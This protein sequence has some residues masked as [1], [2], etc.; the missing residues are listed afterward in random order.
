MREASG[1]F[2]AIGW[3]LAAAV[4]LAGCAQSVE[5]PRGAGDE[6]SSLAAENDEAAATAG[7]EIGTVGAGLEASGKEESGESATRVPTQCAPAQSECLPPQGW[8]KKL[9]DGVF[10]E[11]ALYMFQAGTPW[12][13]MYLRGETEAVNASGGASV[14]GM[15]AFDEEVLILRHR[16]TAGDGIQIGDGSGQYDALRW[17]GS[18]VSLEG[19]ELSAQRPPRPKHSRVEWKWL[20]DG[21]RSALK[22][23]V[24]VRQTYG[25]RRK[26][27]KG[28]SMGRVSQ[29]CERLD[30]QLVDVIVQYV[31]SGASLPEPNEQP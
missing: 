5:P 6:T 4:Q 3:G 28:A 24:D 7:S 9:C 8:V 30:R 12:Q 17:N 31:R 2:R 16:G 11:V 29:K 23:D 26:E 10:P 25:A 22:Q 14:A 19:G 20:G 27:C 1:G 15:M 13:R 21:M 18:C